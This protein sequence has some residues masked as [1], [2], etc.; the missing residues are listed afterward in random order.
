VHRGRINALLG[1][2]G[3]LQSLT[4]WYPPSSIIGA[5]G[6][7]IGGALYEKSF[8]LPLYIQASTTTLAAIIALATLRERR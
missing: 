3:V 4:L 8:Q 2:L 7:L 6:S 5:L 1:A